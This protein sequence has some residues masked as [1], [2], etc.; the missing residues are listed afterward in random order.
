[1]KQRARRLQRGLAKLYPDAHCALHY[2]NPLQLLI[3]TILSAQCTDVRVNMVTPGLFARYADAKA[4]ADA[5]QAELE[6]AI[7]STGFFRNKSKS[8][9]ACCKSIVEKH[10]GEVPNTMEDLVPLPGVGRKTANVILGNAFDVPGIVVDTHVGRLARRMGLTKAEDPEKVEIDLMAVIPKK[11][12]TMFSHRMIFHG[13]QVCQAR[14][15]NCE[16]CLV[17][18][19]CPKIGVD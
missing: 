6:Q 18:K 10:G 17:A 1:M 9:I 2:E 8:I 11:E 14:K 5:D 3:A 19:D 13:R 15:P 12:W 16:G 4:L 7:K